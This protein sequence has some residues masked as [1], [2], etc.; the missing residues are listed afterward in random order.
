MHI[1]IYTSKGGVINVHI[2]DSKIF[3]LKSCSEGLF[4]TN[5]NDPTMI[6]NTNNFSHN[7]YSYI[8]TVKQNLEFFTGSLIEGAQKVLNL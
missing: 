1:K 5:I 2:K 7:S 8:S 3:H 6:T 4:Y